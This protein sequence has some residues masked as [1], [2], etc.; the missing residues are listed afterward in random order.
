MREIQHGLIQ[1]QINWHPQASGDYAMMPI[2]LFALAALV[3]V[4]WYFGGTA[5]DGELR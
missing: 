1:E 5:D 2:V 4:V 3:F